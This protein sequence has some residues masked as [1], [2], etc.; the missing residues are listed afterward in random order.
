MTA[1][2]Q[3]NDKPIPEEIEVSV[4]ASLENPVE[5][6]QS[7]GEIIKEF[8][9]IESIEQKEEPMEQP[10]LQAEEPIL[11]VQEPKPLSRDP[12]DDLGYKSLGESTEA[13]HTTVENVAEKLVQEEVGH[14]EYIQDV[15]EN[16][17]AQ[18]WEATHEL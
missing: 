4:E 15:G 2:A 14:S 10:I 11:H 3:V 18:T 8:T 17:E 9:L 5:A 7:T 16:Q 6:V 1:F 12:V 13:A